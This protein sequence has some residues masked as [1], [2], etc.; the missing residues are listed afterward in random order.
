MAASSQETVSIVKQAMDELQAIA[1]SASG[2]LQS[3]GEISSSS[4]SL[5]V[6]AV[7]LQEQINR[8]KLK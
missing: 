8:F 5:S 3:M 2:Q 7:D 6:L 4:E 1:K